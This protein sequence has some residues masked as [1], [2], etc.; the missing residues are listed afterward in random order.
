MLR[1]LLLFLAL[2]QAAPQKAPPGPSRSETAKLFF[3][4][5][6]LAK[7]QEI[8]RAG[9]S[10]K[11]DGKKCQALVKLLAEYAFLAG[12]I[13]DFTPEQ[14]R[15]FLELDAKITPDARGKLTKQALE[16]FVDRPL[17]IAKLRAEAG[18][19]EGARGI[20]QD[21][22]KVAPKHPETLAFLK[23]LDAP[24]GGAATGRPD[25]GQSPRK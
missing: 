13:D 24:D 11:A 1:A 19:R 18:D 3:L 4:T 2:S 8:A 9:A 16:R 22:L 7:A 17:S 12:R 20:A 10:S 5:G 14:A 21:I 15:Q 23:S 25:G 6:D